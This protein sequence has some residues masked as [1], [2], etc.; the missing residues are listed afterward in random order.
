VQFIKWTPGTALSFASEYLAI[1]CET[2]SKD[3][4]LANLK[5]IILADSDKAYSIDFTALADLDP[6]I[7]SLIKSSKL[8][9]QNF[10]Y[11]FH[12]LQRHGIDLD[13][14]RFRDIMLMHHIIDENSEHS[15]DAQVKFS[16]RDNYKEEFWGKYGSYENAS[17]ASRLEY[18]CKDGIYTHRLFC[19]YSGILKERE[20]LV[21][22]V[23]ELAINLYRTERDGVKVDVPVILDTMPK[24]HEEIEAIGNS[25]RPCVEEYCQVWELNR[26]TEEL[27]KRKTERGKSG[28]KK[29]EF[30]FS[31]GAQVQWLLYDALKLPVINKT[32]AG[33]PST[34][35][36]TL[37]ELESEHSIV[38]LLKD[39]KGKQTLYNTFV[40]G[41]AERQ[42]DG[43]IYPDFNVNGTATGRI[44]SSNPNLQNMPKDGPY[45]GFFI[46]DNDHVFIGADY[47]QLEVVVEANLTGDKNLAKIILEGTSKHDITNEGLKMGDRDKAKT[48]NFA[49]GYHCSP[50]KVAEIL[51]VSLKEAQRIF[52]EYWEIYKGCKQLK[53]FTDKRV[54]DGLPIV[55]PLGRER[56]L[57]Q[58][59]KNKG[60][61]AR[62]KRQAYNA[63]I[64][65]TGADITHRAFSEFASYIRNVGFG[66]ALWPIHDEILAQTLVDRAEEGKSKLVDIMASAVR[67][68][69]WKIPLSAKAY[70]ALTRWQKT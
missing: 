45:R 53:S 70:G 33:K 66:R 6:A 36:D 37:T 69:D 28:V 5:T 41:L 44:S 27:S 39:Y 23:H 14:S 57:P 15:L 2:D 29:P 32:K 11:D 38:A 21:K 67:G 24:M 25:L 10:K 48:L 51:D 59:F 62:A 18:E 19:M 30:N 50:Y 60:E 49:M 3:P 17:A 12:V 26:W 58:E 54:E 34:D 65:G 64:Q 56:H 55:S 13:K 1:D 47:S 52:D 16:F 40:V 42:R 63:L 61:E 46:P 9:L 43:R 7:V 22:H 68:L 20:S 4:R 8:I 31:S 35:Y